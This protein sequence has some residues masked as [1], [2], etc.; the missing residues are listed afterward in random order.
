LRI[1]DEGVT[2][3]QAAGRAKVKGPTLT[4]AV[5][6]SAGAKAAINRKKAAAVSAVLM[7]KNKSG[8]QENRKGIISVSVPPFKA[9]LDSATQE[10]LH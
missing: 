4:G 7:R 3:F 10:T 2:C 5:D 8:T 6:G 1:G 9:S